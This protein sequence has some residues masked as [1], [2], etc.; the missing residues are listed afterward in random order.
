[1]ACVHAPLGAGVTAAV[2]AAVALNG[3]RG[4]CPISDRIAWIPCSVLPAGSLYASGSWWP[5]D[6]PRASRTQGDAQADDRRLCANPHCVRAERLEAAHARYWRRD[7]HDT[8][9]SHMLILADAADLEV[10]TIYRRHNGTLGLVI[11]SGTV[12]IARRVRGVS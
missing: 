12:I 5:R 8:D 9:D 4:R 3:G 2:A 11:D 6:D 1:M 7:L 10:G